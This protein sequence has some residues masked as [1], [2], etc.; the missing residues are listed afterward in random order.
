MEGF[1]AYEYADRFSSALEDL[2]GWYSSGTLRL[3]EEVVHGFDSLP[4]C[5]NRVFEGK[6]TGK[7]VIQIAP[8]S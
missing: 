1:I 6:H 7:L 4:R 2:V 3:M 5:L 8:W